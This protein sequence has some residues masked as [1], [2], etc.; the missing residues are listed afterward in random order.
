MVQK[1]GIGVII[2]VGVGLFLILRNRNGLGS[3]IPTI[4]LPGE[5]NQQL[6][7]EKERLAQEVALAQGQLNLRIGQAS[8]QIP[9][10]G[11]GRID[12]TPLLVLAQSQ[13]TAAKNAFNSFLV[14]NPGV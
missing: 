1:L 11:L 8:G 13:L 12:V 4:D 2:A 14:F 3:L 9:G 5:Q 10:L 7:N 6:Q